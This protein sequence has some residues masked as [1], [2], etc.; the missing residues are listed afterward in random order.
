MLC[1]IYP[2][3]TGPIGVVVIRK[4]G[5]SMQC[6]PWHYC[7]TPPSHNY[8][9]GPVS[10]ALYLGLHLKLPLCMQCKDKDFLEKGDKD[11][12]AAETTRATRERSSIISRRRRRRR[13]WRRRRRRRRSELSKQRCPFIPLIGSGATA[14][15]CTAL[16]CTEATW[17][18]NEKG[19]QTSC[20]RPCRHQAPMTNFPHWHLWMSPTEYYQRVVK[21][22]SNWP[23][24]DCFLN[25]IS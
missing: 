22:Q 8:G 24:A 20:L 17:I 3:Q 6:E 10:R 11:K 19:H 15:Q 14:L 2:G 25:K 18:N 21:Q 16:H 12:F 1:V 9:T 13:G 4:V 5:C 23:E 7:T